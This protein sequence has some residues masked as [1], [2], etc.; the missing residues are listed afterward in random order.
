MT[1]QGPLKCKCAPG[2][3]SCFNASPGTITVYPPASNGD[4]TP[5][6]TISGPNTGIGSP[7]GITL[8][9]SGNI[10][11]LNDRSVVGTRGKQTKPKKGVVAYSTFEVEYGPKVDPVLIFARGS[12][13]DIAPITA[14]G[15]PFT[16]LFGPTAIAVG[17]TVP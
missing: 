15:G 6:A 2:S 7:Y 11:V 9:S 12:N 4:V 3:C 10:C 17:P 13:G 16:G 5:V 1:N 14:L 8:D